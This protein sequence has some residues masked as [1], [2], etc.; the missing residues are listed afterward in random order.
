MTDYLNAPYPAFDSSYPNIL[1]RQSENQRD[2]NDK[3]TRRL[4]D[5]HMAITQLYEMVKSLTNRLTD[6]GATIESVQT[7]IKA[8]QTRLDELNSA[9]NSVQSDNATF[10]NDV[11]N[12]ITRFQSLLTDFQGGLTSLTKQAN[13]N[14]ADITTLKSLVDPDLLKQVVDAWNQAKTDIASALNKYDAETVQPYITSNDSRVTSVESRLNALTSST[15]TRINDLNASITAKVDN[16]L[17]ELSGQITS[18]V[19]STT[20]HVNNLDLFT[21]EINDGLQAEI[22]RAKGAED[23]VNG[24]VDALKTIVSQ[25]KETLSDSIA[26]VDE[27]SKSRDDA[28]ETRLST[29]L[30]AK[31]D[32]D[33]SYADN[34]AATS[35][36]SAKTYADSKASAALGEAKDY[37]NKTYQGALDTAN[38]ASSTANTAMATVT[39]L[40]TTVYDDHERLGVVESR[41]DTLSS[42]VSGIRKTLILT[43]PFVMEPADTIPETKISFVTIK[44][45]TNRNVTLTPDVAVVVNGVY[46]AAGEAKVFTISNNAFLLLT[47]WSRESSAKLTLQVGR[48]SASPYYHFASDTQPS[49]A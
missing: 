9:V 35:L 32:A 17:S 34:A 8:I 31:S 21:N 48:A 43:P 11:Q 16:R 4:Y 5:E 40:R 46:L 37:T 25:N 10:K 20:I 19:N 12:T 29:T 2:F 24:R 7:T 15:D 27:A 23:S 47:V 6:S 49:D 30:S 33:R 42:E 36:D 26:S 38:N 39:A 13:T 45:E 41:V 1:Q 22:K 44:G 18:F 14:T 28:M 3:T